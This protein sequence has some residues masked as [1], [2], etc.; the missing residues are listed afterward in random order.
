MRHGSLASALAL[1]VG[2]LAAAQSPPLTPYHP[3]APTVISGT[4]RAEP[5]PVTGLPTAA[6][7]DQPG[8]TRGDKATTTTTTT[9]PVDARPI[10]TTPAPAVVAGPSGPAC[11]VTT[12]PPTGLAGPSPIGYA[13]AGP[14][15]GEFWASIE[16]LRWRV[17]EDRVPPLATTG[18]AA[19]PVGFLG[20]AG[21]VVL[22]NGDLN[23]DAFNGVR[24]RAGAWCDPCHKY[25][26]EAGLFSLEER[27][28]RTVFGNPVLARP[29]TSINTGLPNSEFV[30]FPGIATGTLAIENKFKFCGADLLGRC[31]VCQDCTSRLDVIGGFQYLNL[32]EELTITE[33]PTFAATAPFPGLAGVAFVAADRFRTENHFYGGVVGFDGFLYSGPCWVELM[34]SVAVGVNRQR[35]EISG[36]QRATSP[37]GA[38]T[39]F[40]GGLLALPG[41]N[42]GRFTNDETSVV[43]QVGVNVGYQVS[44]NCS[45]FAGYSCLYW[46]NV[47]RPGHQIDPV[48]DI[49]RIPNFGTAP[50][51][52]TVRPIVPFNQSDFWAHGVNV[53]VRFSW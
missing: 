25:G 11:G 46:T 37:T 49:N 47:V 23:Q 3:T 41:A 5:V 40:N 29:F 53:G 8:A 38:V 42:I 6:Q 34:G 19:F 1:A 35:I 39:V 31:N 27:T 2:G 36:F 44:P 52:T 15:A 7:A 16:Y 33:T 24:V 17:S 32:E 50:A 4:V 10:T 12:L 45:V 30:A 43:P 13:P 22:F 48:L 14:Y 20:N 26:V 21:T 28:N 9:G 18:P 51:A